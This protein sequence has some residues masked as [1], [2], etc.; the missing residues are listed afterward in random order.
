MS[1]Q[2]EKIDAV[3][4]SNTV[5]DPSVWFGATGGIILF[6]VSIIFIV[7]GIGLGLGSPFRLGTGAFPFITGMI[8][9]ALS[10]AICFYELRGDGLASTPDWIGFCAICSAL[11]VFALTA[12]KLG[13]V[14]AAFLTVFVA[15]LP[16]RSL[17]LVGKII[18]G[19]CVGAVCWILF[20]ELLNL[21]FKPFVGL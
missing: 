18:L 6:I 14:P 20:I 16:D 2:N 4:C 21:P 17:S 10:L 15:S 13:L 1:L 3:E 8:L 7:G 9:G 5:S 12:E 11:A 19:S